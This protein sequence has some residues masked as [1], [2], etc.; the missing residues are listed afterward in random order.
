MQASGIIT[1][2]TDFGH[3]G[4][5]AAVMK[6]VILGRFPDA[7]VVDLAHD[8][9]A[10]WPPEAGFWVRYA[11]RYFPRGTVHV[12]IV[13]PGVGTEREILLVESDHHVFLAPD[14]GLL[15][16]LLDAADGAKVFRLNLD[17]LAGLGITN[18]SATF[19]GRDIFAPLAAEIAAGRVD[20]AD[21]GLPTS[22]WTPGWLDEPDVSAHRVAGV[23]VTVDAFGNLISN[24]D[25]GLIESFESAVAQIGGHTIPILPTYGRARPGEFLALINSFGVIEVARAEGNAAE[26]LGLER[27]APLVILDTAANS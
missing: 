7:R 20:V 4:P 9:P 2:T 19:H 12:A 24:I 3:K 26:G 14:N 8:I 6:G 17:D 16:G 1:I 11:Y 18:P 23:I 25:A 22:D 27:G 13:D 5:F 15:G 21:V 10:Q